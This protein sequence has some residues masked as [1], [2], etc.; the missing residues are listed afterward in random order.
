VLSLVTGATGFLGS[1][2]A[3][4]LAAR[5]DRV[6]ALVRRTSDTRR[7]AGVDVETA[8][9]DVTDA[10]S[11]VRA[12]AGATRVF[13]CAAV[14]EIGARDPDRM[15]RV[16]VEGTRHVL[17]AVARSN[18]LAVHVSSVV[19]LGPTPPGQLADESHWTGDAPRAPYEATKR[20][21][22]VLA[23]A[24][25]SAGAS[26]RIGIP[27]TIYGPDDPSLT[28]ETHKWIARGA[29]RVGALADVPMTF[30]HVD[31]CAEAIVL[32]AERAD[33]RDEYVLAERSVTFKEWFTLAAL[34]AGR[35]P[36]SVW[37]P[38]GVVHGF[39]LASRV[40]PPVVREGLAMSLGVRWAFRGDKAKRDLDWA[41]RPFEEGLR[42]TMA[43]YR[44]RGTGGS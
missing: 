21:A 31:D 35:R 27:V 36:P 40:L 15:R 8:F 16:N 37:L 39:A 26:V 2:V 33:D 9:G 30:V 43:F 20:E 28:G 32:L 4:A 29:M 41:P 1:R 7:L 25:A 34:A 17:D 14:Y 6:R 12:L 19:A 38:D 23:R 3:R 42:E 24:A 13:H 11:V 22:H 5:G 10:A 18:A 44:P